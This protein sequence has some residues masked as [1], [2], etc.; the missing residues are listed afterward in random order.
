LVLTWAWQ[1]AEMRPLDLIK[2]SGNM[3]KYAADFF[4]PNF[5]DWKMY[6]G[7]MLI[8]VQ[9]AIWGTL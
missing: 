5:K 6:V 9:I 3:R 4:P 8:T 7:E 1:G 2:D